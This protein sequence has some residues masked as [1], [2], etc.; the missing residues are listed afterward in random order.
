MSRPGALGVTCT[1]RRAETERSAD[2]VRA[3]VALGVQT[4]P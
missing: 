2:P 4:R 1:A 3:A